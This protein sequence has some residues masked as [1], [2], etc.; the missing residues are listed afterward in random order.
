MTSVQNWIDECRY[1]LEG[2]RSEEAN[3][4]DADYTAGGTTLTLRYDL[5]NINVGAVLAIG[6]NTFRVVAVNSGA[7][8]ATVIP[9]LLSSTDANASAGAMVR[10]NPRFT[11]HRI[12]R[13]LNDHL[14]T[15]STPAV[16]LFQVATTTLTYSPVYAGYNL[17]STTGLQRVLEVRRETSGPE[18]SWPRVPASQWDL[19]VSAPTTDFAA[20]TALRLREGHSGQSIQVVYAKSFTTTTDVTANVSTT[21]IPTTAEDIPPLGAAIRLMSGREVSRNR[22]GSQGD[23]RRANEV[24]PGAVAASYRGLVALW[25]QRVQEEAARLRSQ[26]PVGK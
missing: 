4:L 10:V 20:G 9:G 16:G 22:T 17:A 6:T 15:L 5:G 23:T 2:D 21:G 18:K 25:A 14:Y 7:K 13:A 19:L 26:F 11:D 1:H 12:L 8:T 24:P 3:I